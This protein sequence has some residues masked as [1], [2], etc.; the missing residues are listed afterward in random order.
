MGVNHLK[1]GFILMKLSEYAKKNSISYQTAWNHFNKGLIPNARQLPSGTVVV[2]EVVESSKPEY[3]IVYARVS[4]SE[5]KSNLDSQATRLQQFCEAKGWVV[6]EVVKECA[7]GLN[8][9]RP[10]LSKIFTERKATKLVIEHKDRLTRF[11]FNYIKMLFNDC[12][13]IVVNEC[14]TDQDLFEDFVSLVT[15]FCARIYGKR[16]TRRKTEQ[17]INALERGDSDVENDSC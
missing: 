10:K 4:S 1:G 6:N 15:S 3:V 11:G 13:I 2:D 9:N 8:D 5:N 16:R 14:E 7:S 12:D 17:I